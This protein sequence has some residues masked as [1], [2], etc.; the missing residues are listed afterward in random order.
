MIVV[1]MFFIGCRIDQTKGEE[2]VSKVFG[3]NT[4]LTEDIN[5]EEFGG[6]F[7]IHETDSIV[8]VFF[9]DDPYTI[10]SSYYVDPDDRKIKSAHVKAIID[11]IKSGK[12]VSETEPE[13]TEEETFEE[14]ITE[15]QPEIGTVKF[16]IM[17]IVIKE[18]CLGRVQEIDTVY[19]K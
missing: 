3:K 1:T 12:N 8:R 6:Y 18:D 15:K 2:A 9:R 16:S 4:Y 11:R 17:K 19:V 5:D 14:M 13:F 10:E 7:Y